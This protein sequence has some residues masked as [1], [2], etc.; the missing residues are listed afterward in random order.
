MGR[1]L[2]ALSIVT[3]QRKDC[4]FCPHHLYWEHVR[5]VSYNGRDEEDTVLWHFWTP[6][7]NILIQSS[8]I[9]SKHLFHSPVHH[10][11]S[12]LSWSVKS[13]Q[14][15]LPNIFRTFHIIICLP[16]LS[17]FRGFQCLLSVLS[18]WLPDFALSHLD[19]CKKRQ[20]AVKEHYMLICRAVPCCITQCNRQSKRLWTEKPWS[21]LLWINNV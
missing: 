1:Y 18:V 2:F 6:I 5:N 11:C 14:N 20:G 3:P 9:F 8:I 17:L 19:L 7:G 4:G 21:V 16:P 10:Y 13:K 15:N 12:N